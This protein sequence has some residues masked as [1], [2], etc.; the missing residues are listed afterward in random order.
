MLHITTQR[1]VLKPHTS[2]SLNWLNT[3]CND[4]NEDYYNGDDPPKERPETLEET[5]KLLERILNRPS[6]ADIIDYA[7]H[8]KDTD[9]MIGYGMIALISRYNKRCSLGI[10]LGWNR[11]NW[12]QGIASETLQAVISY[13]FTELDLNRIEAEIYE[14]NERSIRLFEKQGFHRDG[15]RRQYIFKDG[16]FKDEYIYSLLREEW[17][18]R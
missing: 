1:L 9:E 2:N 15:V 7:I 12:G 13:C 8:K 4:P 11:E 16:V 18:K 10:G 17:A 5:G 3:I 6:D 14:F